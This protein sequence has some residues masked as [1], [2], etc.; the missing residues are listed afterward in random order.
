MVYGT[1]YNG[2]PYPGRVIST[3]VYKLPMWWTWADFGYTVTAPWVTFRP[4][5]GWRRTIRWHVNS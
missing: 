2:D 4:A 3:A 5:P 1:L